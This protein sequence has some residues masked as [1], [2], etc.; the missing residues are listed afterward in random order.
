M[1]ELQEKYDSGPICPHCKTELSVIW[2]QELRGILG[3]RYLYFCSNCRAVLGVSHRKG[4]EYMVN[5][6]ALLLLITIEDPKGE[7]I[8]TGKLFEYLASRKP[9]IAITPENGL[10]ANIIKSLN[11]GTVISPRKVQRIKKAIA[12]Y[13]EQWSEGKISTTPDKTSNITKYSRKVLTHKLAQ[14]FEKL[15]Q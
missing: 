15:V 4:L 5:S 1:L 3:K 6:Q 14:I 10:A 7:G 11:A 12:D 2:F 13:Y 9:I 8:L